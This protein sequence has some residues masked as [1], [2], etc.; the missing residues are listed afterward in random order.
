[1]CGNDFG[2]VMWDKKAG[3]REPTDPT[4]ASQI[5]ALPVGLYLREVL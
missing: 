1:M 3:C 5:G 4:K 2:D